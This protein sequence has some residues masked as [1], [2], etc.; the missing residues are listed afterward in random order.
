MRP[1]RVELGDRR[2]VRGLGRVEVA[3][4]DEL[5]REELRLPA[6]IALGVDH[7]DLRLRRLRLGFGVGRAGVRD[8][9]TRAFDLR[10]LV[11]DRGLGRVE[12]GLGLVHLRFED[13]GI[14]PGDHV[15]L[16]NYRVEVGG[17]LRDL[18]RD[19]APHLDGDHGVEVAGGGDGGGKGP[20]LDAGEPIRRRAC[21]VV[22]GR[23]RPDAGADQGQQE[24][25]GQNALHQERE[26]ARRP[27]PQP[28]RAVR[29]SEIGSGS[30]FMA[31]VS[32]PPKGASGHSSMGR[33]PAIDRGSGTGR[34]A[35]S[36]PRGSRAQR[37]GPLRGRGSD[38]P[39]WPPQ[40]RG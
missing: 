29:V 27:G 10:L 20:A 11:E 23:V 30:T 25:Q 35:R 4:G 3:L 6:Q 13:L 22:D 37:V 9:G 12:V 18:A 40:G 34:P 21:T 14:D 31:T 38:R 8:V 24:Y 16:S 32:E 19:L 33:H 17:Q 36:A 1:R 7:G 15:P 39:R 26:G 5:S 28:H 2:V